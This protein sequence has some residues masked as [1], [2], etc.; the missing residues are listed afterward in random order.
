M[1]DRAS[2]RLAGERLL[3]HGAQAVIVTA[4][5]EGNLLLWDEEERWFPV[6]PVKRVDST[7]AGDAFAAGIA[8]GLAE[9]RSLTEATELA[10]AAAAW[11]TTQLGAQAGLPTREQA[12]SLIPH[13]AERF[14]RRLE[15]A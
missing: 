9:G 4:G 6:I 12:L 1:V 11:K 14:R 5:Q 3:F 2:A 8:V 13:D 10:T 15:A 7:G